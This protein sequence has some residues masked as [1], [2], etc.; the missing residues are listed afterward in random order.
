MSLFSNLFP[1]HSQDGQLEGIA[2]AAAGKT[3]GKV[4]VVAAAAGASFGKLTRQINYDRDGVIRLFTTPA[5]ALAQCVAG[6]GDVIVVDASYTT[7][8]TDAEILEAEAKGVTAYVADGGVAYRATATL[9]QSTEAPI[10]TV[11]GKIKLLS[12]LGEVTTVIQTQANNTKLI[13]NPTV[14]AD[15]DLCAVLNISA[16]AVG[17]NYTITGTLANAMVEITSGA[18]VAQ[19]APLIILPGTIDLSCAASNTGAIK[20]QVMYEAISPGA[21]VIAA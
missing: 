1:S 21:R 10:F 8:W 7:A 15:V 17:T 12:I 5:A 6:R 2:I 3:T 9:P 20:W 13:S 4:M 14:G 19:A 18:G 16:D 11:T